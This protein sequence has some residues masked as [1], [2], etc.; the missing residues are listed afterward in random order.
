VYFFIVQ[1]GTVK[2][3]QNVAGASKF[4]ASLKS[5]DYF[6]EERLL[7]MIVVHAVDSPLYIQHTHYTHD[8][9]YRARC[10]CS[11]LT[12]LTILPILPTHCTLQAS[13]LYSQ[14]SPVLA[15]SLPT[16]IRCSAC[17]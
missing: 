7:Y 17:R 14:P 8:T 1:D 2:V 9:P 12:I 6:G 11:I 5:G 3:A 16:P 10:K 13:V 15:T 4:I